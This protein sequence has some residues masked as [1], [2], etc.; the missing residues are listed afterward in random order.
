[1][2]GTG[3]DTISFAFRDDQAYMALDNVSVSE[4]SGGTT[5]EPSTLL[6]MATGVAGL[7]GVV[8]RK[9]RLNR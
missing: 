3:S 5:P 8:R 9:L 1:M 6:M 7:G 2:T 4:A